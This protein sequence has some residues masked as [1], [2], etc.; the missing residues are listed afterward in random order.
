M[1]RELNYRKSV[2]P[3]EQT[4]KKQVMFTLHG[5]AVRMI[6]KLVRNAGLKMAHKTENALRNNLQARRR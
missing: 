1:N 6:S 3:K 4:T 2:P 5:P